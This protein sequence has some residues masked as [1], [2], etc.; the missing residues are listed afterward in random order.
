MYNL[1][2]LKNSIPLLRLHC[3]LSVHSA[4]DRHLN[5]FPG[6]FDITEST[7]LNIL[8]HITWYT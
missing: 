1:F 8:I 5:L 2:S 6:F 7:I 4:V 3:N